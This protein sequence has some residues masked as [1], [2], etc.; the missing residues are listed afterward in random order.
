MRS[1]S[2]EADGRLLLRPSLRCCTD[3][4][5]HTPVDW[6][7]R[8]MR[9]MDDYTRTTFNVVVTAVGAKGDGWNWARDL[10]T[11]TLVASI[12]ELGAQFR[13]LVCAGLYGDADNI[14]ITAVRLTD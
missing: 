3:K 6:V 9:G 14:T 7:I 4:R 8:D 2:M 11:L 12:A 10:P 5:F 13:A 1:D